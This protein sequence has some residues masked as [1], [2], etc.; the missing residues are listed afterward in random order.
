LQYSVINSGEFQQQV[1]GGF[2]FMD[3]AYDARIQ[4][5]QICLSYFLAAQRIISGEFEQQVPFDYANI[6]VN[7][8]CSLFLSKQIQNVL[9][10][11]SH[12]SGERSLK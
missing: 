1:L 5:R 12:A 4:E 10:G 8:E 6:L 7:T 2:F 9:V 3:C 11:I